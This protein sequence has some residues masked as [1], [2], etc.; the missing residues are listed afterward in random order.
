MEIHTDD[1]GMLYEIPNC[2]GTQ[3][4][5]TT[6]PGVRRGDHYHLHKTETFLV[7][8]GEA[9]I[10]LRP[11]TVDGAYQVHRV[12]GAAPY[13]IEIKPLTAHAIV[14][15]GTTDLILLVQSDWVFDANNIDTYQETV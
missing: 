5:S 14:N 3:F 8:S 9:D 11:L 4:I 13:P 15:T 10:L 7:L 12:S 2:T 1:R 6:K